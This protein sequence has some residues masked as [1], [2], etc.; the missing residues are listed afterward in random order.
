MLEELETPYVL[1]H[2]RVFS[3]DQFTPEFR[4]LNPLSKAPVLVDAG[5][6][7]FESGAIL[8]YLAE[9]FGR[10]LA[11]TGTDRYETL[12]WLFAQTSNVGPIF[13]QFNHFRLM[14]EGSQPYAVDRYRAITVRLLNILDERL[15]AHRYLA[16]DAY[17]IADIATYH[18]AGYVEQYAMDWDDFPNL[19]RWYGEIAARP[20]VQRELEARLRFAPPGAGDALKSAS[21]ADLDR[22]FW[23]A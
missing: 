11:P 9:K 19:A 1:R 14:K 15:A 2:V 10:F 8:I 13:G 3:G 22:F 23:R 17:T 20:A 12:K 18:W 6:P 4:A 7:V 16:G 5:Y 21:K